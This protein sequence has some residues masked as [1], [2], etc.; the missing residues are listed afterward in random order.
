MVNLMCRMLIAVGNVDANSLIDAMLGMASDQNTRHELNTKGAGTFQHPNGWG[1]AY[2]N[3]KKEWFIHKSIKPMYNDPLLDS[4]RSIKTKM[5]VLHVRRKTTGATMLENTHPFHAVVPGLGDFIF[6]HNG[7]VYDTIPYDP[8]FKT[9]IKG[10]TDS[11]Q[12]FY[13]LLSDLRSSTDTKLS[14]DLIR[15]NLAQYK[16]YTGT[17]IIITTKDTSFIALKERNKYP[18]YYQM[19]MGTGGGQVIVSSEN[20]ALPGIQWQLLAH[21]DIVEI[22]TA[23][24]V[25]IIHTPKGNTSAI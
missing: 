4:F 5:L 17:N 15:K 8:A 3:E 14:S 11:E 19:S 16:N 23:T 13:S 22:D 24:L 7:T 21:E 10:A 9:Q 12:L 18:H 2:L 25:T 1:I 6:C 20:V